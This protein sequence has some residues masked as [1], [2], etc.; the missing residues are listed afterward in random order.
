MQ[1]GVDAGPTFGDGPHLSCPEEPPARGTWAHACPCRMPS[2]VPAEPPARAPEVSSAFAHAD[3]LFGAYMHGGSGTDDGGCF[4]DPDTD[5][6]AYATSAGNDLNEANQLGDQLY[7]QYWA[8]KRR[9]RRC[10]AT[11]R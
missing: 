10:A 11:A 2:R 1:Y 8:A 5:I 6:S 7:E 4:Q 3:P 9:W